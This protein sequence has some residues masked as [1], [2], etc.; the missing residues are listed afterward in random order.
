[1][2]ETKTFIGGILAGAFLGVAVGILLTNSMS[3]ETREKLVKGAKKITDSLGDTVSDAV[4]GLKEK[5]NENVEKAAAMG[6][7]Q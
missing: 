7:K 6:K 4:D 2:M 1:M 3:G 5:Y